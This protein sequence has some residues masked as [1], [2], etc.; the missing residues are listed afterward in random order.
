LEVIRVKD[1][2]YI[3]AV[4]SLADVRTRVLKHGDT[5][6]VFDRY[7][8]IQ[9]VGLGEQGIYHEGTRFLSQLVLTLGM[10]RPL[11]LGSTVRQD[12]LLL[13]VDLTNPDVTVNGKIVLPR[14]TLHIYRTKFLWQSRCY[15]RFRIWNYG[16]D[17]V[18][19]SFSLQ[20]DAD[21]ADI[22]EVRGLKRQ[23]KGH[24]L[25]SKTDEN[26][27]LFGYEGLD[28][29]LR[30]TRIEATPKPSAVSESTLSFSTRLAPK[31]EATFFITL[32]CESDPSEAAEPQSECRSYACGIEEATVALKKARSDDCEIHT[33]NEQFNDWLN[34]SAADLH[35]MLT[36]MPTG[37]YPYAG[38]PWF[39]TP[40]GRDGIITALEVLWFKP[41]IARGV[42][43]YL[44]ATQA[45]EKAPEQDAEPGKILHEA[46]QGEMAHLGEVPFRRY[47]GSVDATPLFVMLAGAYYQRTGDRPF[48]E[49]IW[50]NITLALKW[51]DN[52]GDRDQDGF[53]EYFRQSSKGLVQQGWKD[54]QDSIF[55]EDGRLAEG[56]IALCEVQGYVY[57]A[58]RYA[59]DLAAMLG[60][61]EQAAELSRQ[62]LELR[63][64][65]EK[66]FWC[67]DLNTYALALDGRKRP[68]RVRTS[69]AGHC[70]FTGIAEPEHARAVATTLLEPISF[71][72]WGIRTVASSEA[73]Y[74]PMSYHNG[75]V[76]PHDNALIAA[77]LA[78]YGL[79]E[80][81]GKVL[82]GLFDSSLFLEL[83][84]LPEL[85][86]GFARG[87]GKGPT[88][89]PVACSPQAWAAASVFLIL[90]ACL[91]M[92][93]DQP[94]RRIYFHHPYLPPYLQKM[95]IRN[96]RVG[97]TIVDLSLE[98]YLHVVGVNVLR[99][100]GQIDVISIK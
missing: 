57:A 78:R 83:H 45:I 56:P 88:L 11:L 22:F 28:R 19:F 97:D 85:F 29:V 84:R 76:W 91:G 6:A 69:N 38:V 13:A 9:P 95:Q 62:A 1:Q 20:L 40:F 49:S 35:M 34:R 41:E 72:G 33:S 64:R 47:Y 53:V 68:C 93:F 98:R 26:G 90:Q 21:Y 12:N 71:S 59:S 86:C 89:Y 30:W 2:Y 58:K 18:D 67:E 16:L 42:L 70:L 100:E 27:I 54:S 25:E 50:P 99:R 14:G 32:T 55:Y 92:T 46:R 60:C 24:F 51:I 77:G 61:Q 48:I 73:R 63:E 79:N 94:K 65:F 23:R 82:T 36:S 31:A 17:A 96:L 15:E 43:S 7:G 52:Y 81:A 4:S 75:S 74:N 80:A 37:P 5:F 8:D 44:A 10:G 39:S 3:L 66:A 87:V